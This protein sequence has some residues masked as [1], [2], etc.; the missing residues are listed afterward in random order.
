MG[1]KQTTDVLEKGTWVLA[2][3][4]AMLCLF[5]AL[6]IPKSST[7]QTRGEGARPNSTQTAPAN[8][9]PAGLYTVEVTDDKGN[10]FQKQILF[11]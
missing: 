5:S 10:S 8:T 1:V 9:P 11:R 7:I 4:I 3:V 6:F 2:F